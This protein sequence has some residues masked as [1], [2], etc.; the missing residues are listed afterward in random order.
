MPVHCQLTCKA[1]KLT[2]EEEYRSEY[3][4]DEACTRAKRCKRREERNVLTGQLRNEQR[5]QGLSYHPINPYNRCIRVKPRNENADSP[6]KYWLSGTRFGVE[7]RLNQPLFDA[8]FD[9]V[10]DCEVVFKRCSSL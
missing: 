5:S 4:Q 9:S 7:S 2:N 10:V 3:A 1:D 8:I 6:S